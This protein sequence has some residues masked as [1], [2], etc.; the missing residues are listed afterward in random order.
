MVAAAVKTLVLVTVPVLLSWA[1][2]ENVPA[3]P[4]EF[5]PPVRL[6]A[7]DAFLGAGR[8]YP[9]PVV[10][11]VDG[12]GRADVVVGDLMGMVTCAARTD[13]EGS[14]VLAA[15]LP[16]TTRKAEQLSFHNW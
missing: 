5:A 2:P 9:S 1:E 12:D 3:A 8:M 15:E 4:A 10:H 16:M 6:K 13:A 7:G 14:P 11:D